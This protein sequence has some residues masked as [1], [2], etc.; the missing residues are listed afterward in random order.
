M[1]SHFFWLCCLWLQV[2]AAQEPAYIHYTVR[3][4]LPGN[5]I[6]SCTQDRRGLLWFGTDKGLACFDGLR[7]H[8]YGV[9]NGLPD[10][11]VL[12]VKEDS[13]GRLWL[14]C[15]Q[16]SPC[17]LKN[18][19]IVTAAEDTMLARLNF[20][21]GTNTMWEDGRGGRW[22]VEPD[23]TIYYVDQ[24]GVSS[25][26]PPDMVY[27][28]QPVGPDFLAFGSLKIMRVGARQD[29]EVIYH[30]ARPNG[31]LSVAVSG[32]HILYAYAN[33]T[34]LLRYQ[35]GRIEKLDSL[36]QPTG[37]AFTDRS[38]RFWVCSTALGATC[39]NND[40]QDLSHPTVFLPGKKVTGMFEDG[41]GT[42]WFCT[43]DEGIFALPRYAPLIYGKDKFPSQNI[44]SLARNTSGQ[45][46]I[47]DN[48][49]NV[50]IMTGDSMQTVVLNPVQQ[51]NQVRQIIPVGSD[52][53]WAVADDDLHFC[54]RRYSRLAKNNK[55][56]G[57]KSAVL[58]DNKVWFAASTQLGYIQTDSWSNH[59]II[60]H[61]FISIGLDATGTI[62]SGDIN[63]LYSQ[64]D[65]F[66]YNWGDRFPPLKNKI[67]AIS[68]AGPDQL[69]LTTPREGLMRATLA[70][71]AISALEII[72][73]GLAHP[74]ENIQSLF[75]EP[76]G[77][78]WMATNRGVYG[79]G[80]DGGLIHF[81]AHDGLSDDDVNTVLVQD[82]TLWV[83]TVSGLTRLILH[84]P[85]QN[86]RFATHVT[87][88]HYQLANRETGLHLL[89][90]LT[91]RHE[92]TLPNDATD[93]ELTLAG[94]DYTSR[95]N[96]HF[97]IVQRQ[98]L[99]PFYWWTLDNLLAQ[100]SHRTLSSGD[101][102]WT[103]EG[104]FRLGAYLP[105]GRYRIQVTAFSSSGIASQFADTW[106]I[107]KP[108]HWYRVIW[109]YILL[110]VAVGYGIWRIY[111]GRLAYQRVRARAST[112]QLQTLQAQINPH[113]IGNAVNAIQQFLHPPNPVKTSEYIALFMR[114][115]R[116][117]MDFSA[118]TFVPFVEEITYLR[119]YLQLN[120][121]RFEDRFSYR[122]SGEDQVPGDVLIPTML[123]QPVVENATIHGIAPDGRSELR[124]HFSWAGSRLRCEVTDNG[125]GYE[126]TQRQ[127]RSAS[128]TRSAKGLLLLRQKIES[129][130]TLYDIEMQFS[131]RDLADSDP[132]QSGTQV[133]FTY[134]PNRIWKALK[135]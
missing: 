32:N 115:L 3:D 15:F 106:V 41:Q 11:E 102:T 99:L 7:F 75:V 35:N 69:Y 85:E 23:K 34:F 123:L 101:S 38:G 5:L 97:S 103:E 84:P 128:L 109:I 133:I 88:L 43:V 112:L 17:Y 36:A 10:P 26:H 24:K 95:G 48:L 122:I 21:S 14:F 49:G 50:H 40:R 120:Q 129:L 110:W 52:A 33:K 16:K 107:L 131:I 19:R 113:F 124:L 104:V 12:R 125:L 73:K 119:E 114:I 111:E 81:D 118:E 66:Q 44:R 77:R 130:N 56:Y 87:D 42:L 6:Y 62:W 25:V 80:L 58:Q 27:S 93:V 20:I 100:F 51:Y 94:L 29:M 91:A 121:L 37:Q 82:D 98:E 9:A 70:D 76:S 74:I 63:G 92:V 108:P 46:F 83:G 134:Y 135:Q 60:P 4:G 68:K 90:S 86:G 89:D 31:T 28:L 61:R 96:L 127:K 59:T 13:Q 78:V 71:G 72:N 39:F 57:L 64:R 55:K 2:S 65:D 116:K 22:H 53:F 8:T 30:M 1:R 45:L 54:D 18:G 126:A 79:L 105:P 117:T 67:T 132:T 47:G